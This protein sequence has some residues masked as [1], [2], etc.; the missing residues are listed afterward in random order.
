[1]EQAVL[2]PAKYVITDLSID[3]RF[4]DQYHDGT[5]DVTFRLPDNYKNIMRLAVSSV[6]VPLVEYTF[7]ERR[8]N[9]TIAVRSSVGGP[10]IPVTIAEGNY[11][12]T[13]LAAAIQ[14]GFHDN[15]V[16]DVSSYTCSYDPIADRFTFSS[17]IGGPKFRLCLID[18]SGGCYENRYWGLGYYMGFRSRVLTGSASYTG[19]QPPQLGPT[20]YYL[21]QVSCPDQ[22]ETTVHATGAQSWIPALA[23]IVLRGSVYT[24]Q[25]DDGANR[26]RKEITFLGPSNVGQLRVRLMDPYGETVDLGDVDW[27]MTFE[28]TAV[29]SSVTYEDLAG[30][31]GRS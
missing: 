26:L 23:K 18:P 9:V 6:E 13:S 22:V 30:A 21:M 29:T 28:I 25:F 17:G 19:T 11:G 2:N 15:V 8:R 12:P 24:M 14:T 5:A 31:F 20:P 3:T 27:S 16:Q 10:V 7:S 4:A 1:M